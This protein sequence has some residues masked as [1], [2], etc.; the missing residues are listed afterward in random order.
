MLAAAAV[1]G[2]RAGNWPAWRGPEGRGIAC[3]TNLPLHW[4]TH[5]NVRWS[6]PLPAPG[7]ST[8]IVWGDKVFVTQGIETNHLRRLFCFSRANGDLLWQAGTVWTNK[9]MGL[10][11][12]PPCSPSPVTDGE[13]VIA[14]FGSAGVFCY[15]L[16]GHELWRRD[17]GPQTHA[18]GY[19]ASPVIHGD[20]CFLN[21][22]PGPRCF[23]LAIE[24][25][26]GKTVWQYD[27]PPIGPDARWEDFGGTAE[28]WKQMRQ[29][30]FSTVAEISGS[31]ATPLVVQT[32][33]REEL[34]VAFE[35]R[36]LAL[37]PRTGQRLWVCAGPNTCAY[38]SP[39]FGDGL[40]YLTESGSR[41]IAMALRP[42][43]AEDV[44][45]THR[46]WHFEPSSSKAC[47]GSPVIYQGHIYQ[48]ASGGAAQCLD[49][50][51]GQVIW[52]HRLAGAG[53]RNAC[54]SSPILA[55]DLLYVPNQ[56]ADVFV[57]RAST[58]FTCLA[59]NSIG[60][61]KMNASLAASNGDLFLRTYSRLW[62][63][64]R[65]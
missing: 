45:P 5:Q 62:C 21:F 50:Q 46:L 15:D 18:W 4:T 41:N 31:C 9:E 14:W 10:D 16:E 2:A 33:A 30:G 11:R 61:E 63:I 54:W 29:M 64:A 57:L 37:A 39:C 32:P 12:N 13:R 8:P 49:L 27:V 35:L 44:A 51:T 28:E 48:V 42:G 56:N 19:A 17:L 65:P 55:G 53:P 7:N 22:G 38:S 24:K 3:E 52:D 34:V 40:I 6:A 43:G 60:G 36:V 20:L 23:V 25:A 47:I 58:N 59:T 26:T 1:A